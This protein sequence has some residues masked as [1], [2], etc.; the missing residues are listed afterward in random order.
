MICDFCKKE[1]EHDQMMI[2]DKPYHVA[3]AV[4]MVMHFGSLE[5]QE[6]FSK[7]FKGL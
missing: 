6:R 5:A 3:C 7:L 1:I 4:T 2:G